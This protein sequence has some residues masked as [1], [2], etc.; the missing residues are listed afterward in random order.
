MLG[1][2]FMLDSINK[3]KENARLRKER[4]YKNLKE[5][6]ETLFPTAETGF[7]NEQAKASLREENNKLERQKMKTRDVNLIVLYTVIITIVTLLWG[8]YILY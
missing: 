1:G 8:Y 3:M 4:R 2:G 6:N 7:L 5:R